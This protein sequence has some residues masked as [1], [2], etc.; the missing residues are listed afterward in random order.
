MLIG[1][2]AR[3]AGVTRDTVRLY[4]RLGLIAC[5]ERVAGSRVYADYEDDVVELIRDI[6]VAKSLGFTLAEIRP[7]V[8]LYLAGDLTDEQQRA[9]LAAKLADVELKQHQL[10]E[11]AA[12]LRTKLAALD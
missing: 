6:Q 10:Q 1:E 7:I 11:M 2:V 4:T 8:V 5:R 3:R 9:T 12:L